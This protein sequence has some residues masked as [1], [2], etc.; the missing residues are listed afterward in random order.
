MAPNHPWKEEGG[1]GGRIFARFLSFVASWGELG[2]G[3][4]LMSTLLGSRLTPVAVRQS[5]SDESGDFGG[6]AKRTSVLDSLGKASSKKPAKKAA[7][8]AVPWWQDDDYDDIAGGT[9][10]GNI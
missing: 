9:G 8:S 10:R 3:I 6:S 4:D 7:V 1:G 5:V 2:L